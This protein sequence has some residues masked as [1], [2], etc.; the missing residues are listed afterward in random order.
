M[1]AFDT[2][3]AFV[4]R[5]EGGYSHDSADPGGE[6]NLGIS[7]RSHPELDIRHLTAEQAAEIYREEYWNPLQCD[8][9]PLAVALVLFDLAVHSGVFR[10]VRMLQRT[11]GLDDDGVIGPITVM[12][13]KH[14]DPV[15]LVTELQLQRLSY[16]ASLPTWPRY[17]IGWSRRVFESHAEAMR[18]IA[19]NAGR[20]CV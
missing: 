15:R 18:L 12:S 19:L 6:T 3:L 1:T 17:R 5:Q 2:A 7:L 10:A 11:L 16:L 14:A 4:L 8:R 13:V 20:S 9:L